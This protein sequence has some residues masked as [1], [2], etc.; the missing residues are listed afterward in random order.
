MSEA[1]IILLITFVAG[2]FTLLGAAVVFFTRQISSTAMALVLSFAS[3]AMIYISFM[4]LLP[5]SLNL[6]AEERGDGLAHVFLLGAFVFGAL[7]A[8]VIDY[9]IP[10]QHEVGVVDG[11]PPATE[12]MARAGMFIF[13]AIV[14]HN[15]PEG[16]G[17]FAAA[18]ADINFGLTVALAMAI[19]NVPEGMVVAITTYKDGRR[20][21]P[22]LYTAVAG[23]AQPLG[24]L[25]GILLLQ[26]F[27]TGTVLGVVNAT[28]AGIMVYISLDA[29][30]PMA[31]AHDEAHHA[32]A[33]FFLGFIFVAA[34]SL[35]FAF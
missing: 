5:E 27:L 16:L 10:Q 28:V 9:F 4:E 6:I 12:K 2:A 21:K 13:I 8:A 29:L 20:A 18:S 30:L 1:G 24:A 34:A 14:V 26:P 23:L 7:C 22:I 32:I 15:L 19:H 25:L 17:I 33:G 3:G 35:L 11:S 31:K